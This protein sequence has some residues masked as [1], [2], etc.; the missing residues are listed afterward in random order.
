MK[1]LCVSAGVHGGMYHYSTQ[2][3]KHLSEHIEVGLIIGRVD[4]KLKNLSHLTAIEVS[5]NKKD[6]IRTILTI[7]EFTQKFQPDIILFTDFHIILLPLIPFF[8]SYNIVTTIHDTSLHPGSD[9]L[10]NR[11]LLFVYLHLGKKLFVHGEIL[12]KNLIKIGI[13]E[14]KIKIIPHGDYSFFLDYDQ[15]EIGEKNEILFF[16][17]IIKYKGLDIL[18]KAM[19]PIIKTNPSIK[20]VIAGE[21]NMDPYLVL[22]REINKENIEIHNYFIPDNEVP[23]FFKRAKCIVLPYIEA[24]Q[25]GIVPIASA[26]KKPVVASN[27][28]AISEIVEN[29]K[30]GILI[31]P[32]NSDSLAESIGYL[33][34]NNTVREKMGEAAFQ[35]MTNELSWEKIILT[36]IEVYKELLN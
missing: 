32:N 20:L 1:V 21:G 13:E 7:R 17:R 4:E 35:K 36:H 34:N 33:L 28:G 6:F 5:Y 27:V 9:T 10:V 8:K 12:R 29:G 22:L 14:S 16:G 31:K 24:S 11:F 25:T 30:T 3:A 15:H 23:I 2:F 19:K 26:F 18:L